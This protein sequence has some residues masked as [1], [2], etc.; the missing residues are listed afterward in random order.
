MNKKRILAVCLLICSVGLFA[1]SKKKAA[2]PKVVSI[3]DS[4]SDL[5]GKLLQTRAD[6]KK[7]SYAF[8]ALSSDDGNALAEDYVTDALTEAVFNTGKIKIYER[9]NLEKIL[10]EQKFQS[11]GLVDEDTAKDIGKIAGVD[12][13]CYGTLK[14]VGD[15]ITVNVRV[16]DVQNGE[17]CAMSRT[18]V[19][20]DNYLKNIKFEARK[21]ASVAAETK[22]TAPAAETAKAKTVNS[23]WKVSTVRNDFDGE[24][25][26]TMKC[27]NPDGSFLFFG[28]EKSDKP[29]NSR[30]RCSVSYKGFESYLSCHWRDLEFKVESGEV[31]KVSEKSDS[32]NWDE[33]YGYIYDRKSDSWFTLF[34]SDVAISKQLLNMYIENDIIYVR[35]NGNKVVRPF[36]TAGFLEVLTANGI[37]L[38]EINKAFANE[39]F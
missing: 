35:D 21:T 26:Y 29:L 20:K 1:A 23:A 10:S 13:I 28:Y 18:T 27:M 31:F 19:D 11:S 24:T 9:A 6:G 30:V 38:D 14:T 39:S 16:V 22:S 2:E 5:A 36:E 3:V 8:V 15:S 12:Y 7:A 34:V 25:I 4:F 17:I 33:N 32:F 37:T